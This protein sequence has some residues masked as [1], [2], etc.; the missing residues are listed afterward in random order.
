MLLGREGGERRKGKEERGKKK[1]GKKKGERRKGKEERGK[2]KGG[3]GSSSSSSRSVA[4]AV[5]A[6]AMSRLKRED[7]PGY[8]ALRGV[9]IGKQGCETWVKISILNKYRAKLWRDRWAIP[10]VR[11]GLSG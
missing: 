5:V 10:P 2:K 3:S 7:C 9:Q 8:L 6:V 4:L 1:G 11:L